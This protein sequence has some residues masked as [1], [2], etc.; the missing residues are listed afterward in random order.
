MK[1]MK[2]GETALSV[3]ISINEV[4]S[5]AALIDRQP[6]NKVV[7]L[8]SNNTGMHEDGR[9]DWAFQTRDRNYKGGAKKALIWGLT[10]NTKLV[11]Q[12][13]V[14]AIT[15]HEPEYD[16]KKVKGLFNLKYVVI[17]LAIVIVVIQHAAKTGEL[18]S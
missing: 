12:T 1:N 6:A 13:L 16:W 10:N 3:D 5:D 14:G 18:M 17:F 8:G 2:K 4:Q 11:P 9:P 15:P 7:P